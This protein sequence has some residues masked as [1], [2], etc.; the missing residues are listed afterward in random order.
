MNTCEPIPQLLWQFLW[1]LYSQMLRLQN[2]RSLAWLITEAVEFSRA[3]P[4]QVGRFSMFDFTSTFLQRPR[5]SSRLYILRH[6]LLFTC[7]AWCV[8]VMWCLCLPIWNVLK[9]LCGLLELWSQTWVERYRCMEVRMLLKPDPW[10]FIC[11]NVGMNTRPYN[12]CVQSSHACYS[13]LTLED[14]Y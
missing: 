4:N 5:I 7:Q 3:W 8:C 11:I 10:R 6:I 2:Y 1:K 9:S 12:F 13:D 14:F